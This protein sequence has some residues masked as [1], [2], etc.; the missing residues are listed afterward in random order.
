MLQP[1]RHEGGWEAGFLP[2][3]PGQEMHGEGGGRGFDWRLHPLEE[4]SPFLGPRGA[5]SLP[6]S[7]P[8]SIKGPCR[9]Q[10]SQLEYDWQEANNEECWD[11]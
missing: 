4:L 2:P 1:S 9:P 5:L 8:G 6:L 3:P 10:K 7:G 11:G